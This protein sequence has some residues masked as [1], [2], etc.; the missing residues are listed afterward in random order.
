[1]PKPEP[2]PASAAKAEPKPA[3]KPAAPAPP[4]AERPSLDRTWHGKVLGPE[5]QDPLGDIGYG[6]V[7]RRIIA[8]PLARAVAADKGVDLR[9]VTGTGPSGR[10]TRDDVENAKS[11]PASGGTGL[12]RRDTEVK[13]NSPMR[14]TIARRLLESHQDIPTFF[15]TANFDMAG[16]VAWRTAIK[17]ARPDVKVSYNDMLTACVA[18]ALREHP[19]VN[20]SWDA[21]SITQH[22]QVD[23]GIAV[24]LPDGLITPV[25]RDADLK[26]P[27]QIGTEIRELAGRAKEGKLSED[28]YQGN[29]FTIS[30]LGM[31]AIDEFTAII[32]PPASAILAVGSLQQVPVVDNGQLSVGYRMKVTMT[33]DHRV[34][35]GATGAEFL[36]TLRSYVESPALMLL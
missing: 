8:S 1:E 11:A 12:V 2:E 18:R 34:I 10:I 30:N 16:F 25:V 14:K 22:G 7:Q 13:R 29:T 6:R 35:D 26:S 23:I 4:P 15:L 5:F 28:E 9:H 3:P 36:K 17:A 24:A 21:K 33:C 20:A 32:N 19:Q 27:A 31:Y